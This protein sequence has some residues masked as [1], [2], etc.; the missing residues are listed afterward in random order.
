MYL[1]RKKKSYYEE[2]PIHLMIHQYRLCEFEKD[3][4]VFFNIYA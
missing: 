1:E 4:C 3:Y 2:S